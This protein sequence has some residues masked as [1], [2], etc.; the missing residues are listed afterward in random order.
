METKR[1]RPSVNHV[2]GL[3]ISHSLTSIFIVSHILKSDR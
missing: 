2:S 3:I 1:L